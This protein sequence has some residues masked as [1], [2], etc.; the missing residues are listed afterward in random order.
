MGDVA[1]S[2]LGSRPN[3]VDSGVGFLWKNDIISPF[4]GFEGFNGNSGEGVV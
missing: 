2:G 1:L 4:I 3:P